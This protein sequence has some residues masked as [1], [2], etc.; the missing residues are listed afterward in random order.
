MVEV[1]LDYGIG[2]QKFESPTVEVKIISNEAGEQ[3]QGIMSFKVHIIYLYQNV[4]LNTCR[5]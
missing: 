1:T 2:H 4:R 5:D 3:L